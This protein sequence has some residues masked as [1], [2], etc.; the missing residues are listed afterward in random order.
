MHIYRDNID[1]DLG[2]SHISDKVLIEIL[3][4]MGRG[5]IYDYLL[6]G[7]DVTYEIFLDR[8]KFYLEIIND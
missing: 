7:K 2:I 8:L 1:K 3:D 5:L 4:D 6:F